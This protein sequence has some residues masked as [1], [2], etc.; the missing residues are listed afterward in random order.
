MNFVRKIVLICG[1]VITVFAMMAC[2]SLQTDIYVDKIDFSENI[3]GYERRFAVLDGTENRLEKDCTSLIADIEVALADSSLTNAARARLFA[4]EG[5]TYLFIGNESKAKTLY[6]AGVDAYKGD[7]RGVILASRLG[8]IKNLAAKAGESNEPALIKIEMALVNFKKNSFISSVA[9]FDEAFLSLDSSYRD[10]YSDI[11]N[12]AWNACQSTLDVVSPLVK[13]KKLN[14]GQMLVLVDESSDILMTVTNGKKMSSGELY[15]KVCAAGL[16]DCA[17]VKQDPKSLVKEKDT[18]TK[19]IAARFLWNVWN[20]KRNSTNFRK[21]SERY[22]KAGIDSPVP[23]VSINNQDFDAVLG[24]VENELINLSD[25]RN[26]E[27]NAI[28][29]GSDMAG[30]IKKIK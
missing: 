17:T 18:V 27:G 4:L 22:L 13:H 28:V 9:L 23:D 8:I 21:Y 25:G 14:V 30:Y 1:F 6:E 24:C 2:S 3:T 12:L 16:L 5:L 29:S 10:A 15:K 20:K 7:V 19:Y 11:R 26:F